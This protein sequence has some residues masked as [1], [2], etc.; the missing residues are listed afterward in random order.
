MQL[1]PFNATRFSSAEAKPGNEYYILFARIPEE[2]T[3]PFLLQEEQI[4]KAEKYLHLGEDQHVSYRYRHHLLNT[5][6][7]SLAKKNL[8]EIIYQFNEFRKTNHK[9]FTFSF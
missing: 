6:I 1:F 2:E 7:T 8:S 4:A 5:I 3:I 9:K